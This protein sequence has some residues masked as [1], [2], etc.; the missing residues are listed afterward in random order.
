MCPT[1]VRGVLSRSVWRVVAGSPGNLP[2]APP[3]DLGA[4]T[5]KPLVSGCERRVSRPDAWLVSLQP[6]LCCPQGLVDLSPGV[7][8]LVLGK[9]LALI[10]SI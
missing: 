8:S 6:C 4:R 7:L 5:V 9:R 10:V 2:F 3:D 1:G